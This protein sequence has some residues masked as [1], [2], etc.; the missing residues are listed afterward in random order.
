MATRCNIIVEDGY[1]RIQIYRHWDGYPEAVIPDIMEALP[2]A[3]QLPRFEATDFAAAIV[4]AWKAEGGNIYIDGN[5]KGFELI[6]D[7]V[8]YVYV[9][10]FDGATTEPAV[11]VYDWHDYWFDKAD[12]KSRLFRPVPKTMIPFSG[13]GNKS[14]V[15]KSS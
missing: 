12:T 14:W 4:R 5:P 13:I 8:E 9:I 7:D 10:I 6:H 1:D 15:K 2:Y 3:W 11:T